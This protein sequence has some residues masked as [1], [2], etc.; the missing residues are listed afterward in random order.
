M[1]HLQYM[2]NCFKQFD[3]LCKA[4]IGDSTLF[5]EVMMVGRNELVETHTVLRT[6]S[7]QIS[8][9]HRKLG[10]SLHLISR[11]IY[12]SLEFN[13][14]ANRVKANEESKRKIGR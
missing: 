3:Q 11:L 13:S 1:S 2:W 14:N 10:S 5:A 6:V 4:V 9:L 12:I 7:E 8:H